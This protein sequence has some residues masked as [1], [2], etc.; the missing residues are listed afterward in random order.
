MP[1]ATPT[2]VR[3]QLRTL[4]RVLTWDG[5]GVP[6]RTEHLPGCT[7]EHRARWDQHD[8]EQRAKY[9]QPH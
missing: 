5:H 8:A 1:V 6:P 4:W 9:G 7:P 3:C 2:E